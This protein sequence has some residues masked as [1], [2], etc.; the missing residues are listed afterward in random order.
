MLV[1]TRKKFRESTTSQF[2]LALAITDTLLLWTGL[3]RPWL[4]YVYN[5]PDPRT[6]SDALCKL[7]RFIVYWCG[8]YVAG[9]VICMNIE[10]FTVIFFPLIK[11]R[12]TRKIAWIAL[13]ITGLMLFIVDGHFFFTV[14]VIFEQEDGLI[15][16]YC[17]DIY[18]GFYLHVWPWIDFAF[19]SLLPFII[20]LIVNTSVIGKL[21]YSNYIRRK[22]MN[23]KPLQNETIQVTSMTII[24]FTVS[25]WHFLT[26]GPIS[27]FLI[28][29]QLWSNKPELSDED[30]AYIDFCWAV[31]YNISYLNNSFNFILYIASSSNFRSEFICMCR[32]YK[33]NTQRKEFWSESVKTLNNAKFKFTAVKQ[34][35]AKPKELQ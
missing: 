16:K 22:E 27:V 33:T 1:I 21:L 11:P 5:I 7:H 10:R 9:V 23:V 28:L 15:V 19:Y 6:Y 3:T 29:Q 14:K 34:Q 17:W 12:I 18:Q 30:S 13:L 25:A 20:L 2:L 4:L 35:P 26:T 8:H 24:F 31:V 32:W